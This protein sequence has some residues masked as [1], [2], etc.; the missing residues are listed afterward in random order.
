MNEII[1]PIYYTF[2][3]HP[4]PQWKGYYYLFIYLFIYFLLEHAEADTFFCFSNLMVEIGDN[5]TKKLDR[6][7][8][9][10]GQLDAWTIVPLH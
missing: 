8:A 6:S 4:D 5:F 3:Q 7:R 2:A 10:I 9:G 1:G